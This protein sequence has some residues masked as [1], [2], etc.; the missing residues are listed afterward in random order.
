MVKMALRPL[1]S[2]LQRASRVRSRGTHPTS[3]SI[4]SRVHFAFGATLISQASGVYSR[5]S[6]TAWRRKTPLAHRHDHRMSFAPKLKATLG[7]PAGKR[8]K[9]A[10]WLP[11]SDDKSS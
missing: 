3:S 1:V 9:A 6:I 11:T 8:T 2:R 5:R 10:L 4:S 7:S